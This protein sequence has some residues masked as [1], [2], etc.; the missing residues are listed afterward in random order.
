MAIQTFND[1]PSIGALLGT[2]ISSGISK[3]LEAL[4][5]QKLETVE[6]KSFY[7][8]MIKSG[9]VTPEMAGV[10]IKTP[11]EMRPG[12]LNSLAKLS[13]TQGG[14]QQQ[15]QEEPQA[16]QSPDSIGLDVMYKL[17]KRASIYREK[18]SIKKT[19]LADKRLWDSLPPE[20]KEV[21]FGKE[22]NEK[23]AGYFLT[24]TNGNKDMARKLAKK[25][26]YKV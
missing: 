7:D 12:L 25:F 18:G 4:A 22:L 8:S 1:G 3:S 21:V 23:V 10:I 2:G 14:Q 13:K 24:K 15:T 6:K 11:K 20:E 17:R 26:G 19:K 16:Q 9:L 5:K